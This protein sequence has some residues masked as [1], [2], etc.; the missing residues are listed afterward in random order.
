ML[1][2]LER[3]AKKFREMYAKRLLEDKRID[4][5]AMLFMYDEG[6]KSIIRKWRGRE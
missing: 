5:R 6:V 4:Y 2:D 3:L 1:E